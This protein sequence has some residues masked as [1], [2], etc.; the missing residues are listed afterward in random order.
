MVRNGGAGMGERIDLSVGEQEEV[1]ERH[2]DVEQ[3]WKQERRRSCIT[4]QDVGNSPKE[5][6]VREESSGRSART[7]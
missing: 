5:L 2:R 3:E 7:V 1:A 4:V 6:T